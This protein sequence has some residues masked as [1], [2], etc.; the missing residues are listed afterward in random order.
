MHIE[1][2]YTM[3]Q[4]GSALVQLLRMIEKVGDRP[5]DEDQERQLL[6]L[7]LEA[8]R[9]CKKQ[10]IAIPRWPSPGGRA[11]TA[12]LHLAFRRESIYEYRGIQYVDGPA[13]DSISS[14][15]FRQRMIPEPTEDWLQ[16]LQAA[17]AALPKKEPPRKRATRA[18]KIE[19]LRKEMIDHLRAAHDHARA[20]RDQTGTPRLLPRPTQKDLAKRVDISEYD[21]SRCLKDPAAHELRLLWEVALD[22]G[23][24]MTWKG[25]RGNRRPV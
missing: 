4:A 1:E 18:A 16:W 21:V 24:I 22:L 19:A 13:D 9:V 23:Q 17:S 11:H 25:P 6:K 3:T 2:M 12:G 14:D 8:A 10:G 20:T 15:S 5:L 7:D